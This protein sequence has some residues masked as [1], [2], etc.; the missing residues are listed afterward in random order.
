M[1]LA[2]TGS[3]GR[4]LVPDPMTSRDSSSY[5]L[6]SPNLSVINSRDSRNHVESIRNLFV[7]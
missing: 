4:R 2:Q 7:D 5:R 3:G 1:R 6:R